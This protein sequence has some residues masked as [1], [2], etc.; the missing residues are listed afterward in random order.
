MYR[1]FAPRPLG[2][3][4]RGEPPSRPS[5]HSNVHSFPALLPAPVLVAALKAP[6]SL[7]GLVALP[8]LPLLILLLGGPRG[9]RV[10]S[11]AQHDTGSSAAPAQ[12][13]RTRC[14]C[15]PGTYKRRAF[16]S[17]PTSSILPSSFPSDRG[18]VLLLSF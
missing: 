9:F 10:Y 12:S 2:A 8:K 4:R 5:Q 13:T 7:R 6:G 14:R 15:I 11:Y 3:N 1:S 16:R 17:L 18:G